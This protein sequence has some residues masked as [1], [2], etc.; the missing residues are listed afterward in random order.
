MAMMSS[1]DWSEYLLSL[2]GTGDSGSIEARFLI[3]NP[4]EVVTTAMTS[5]IELVDRLLL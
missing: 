3:E 4:S 5:F 1:I 2:Y